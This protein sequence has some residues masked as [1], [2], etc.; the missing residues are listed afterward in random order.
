MSKHQ[1][2]CHYLALILLSPPICTKCCWQ[3]VPAPRSNHYSSLRM[4]KRGRKT[5]KKHSCEHV[6]M[7]DNG[8]LSSFQLPGQIASQKSHHCTFTFLFSFSLAFNSYKTRKNT[9]C[10]LIPPWNQQHL[11]QFKPLLYPV[12]EWSLQHKYGTRDIPA[13]LPELKMGEILGLDSSLDRFNR[14]LDQP[15]CL[16]VSAKFIQ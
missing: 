12:K 5:G 13:A 10:H 15:Q 4:G 8:W 2:F 11:H 6:I 1:H 3:R 16:E 7:W 9:P 14:L